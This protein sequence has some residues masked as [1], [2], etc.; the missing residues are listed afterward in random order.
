MFVK[1][2]HLPSG[3]A[4][5]LSCQSEVASR[6]MTMPK[7]CKAEDRKAIGFLKSLIMPQLY[8]GIIMRQQ[9]FQKNFYPWPGV[10]ICTL[11]WHK[12]TYP[13]SGG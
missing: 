9:P 13:P 1:K 6:A 12:K 3:E 5:C 10:N 8:I 2:S 7:L 4:G 11:C